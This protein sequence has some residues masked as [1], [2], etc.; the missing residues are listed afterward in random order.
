MAKYLEM[1]GALEK[2]VRHLKTECAAQQSTINELGEANATLAAQLAIEKEKS[3]KLVSLVN[4]IGSASDVIVTGLSDRASE[5]TAECEKLQ[6]SVDKL[7]ASNTELA[8]R[9]GN[10]LLPTWFETAKTIVKESA[11][12]RR[13]MASLS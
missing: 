1:F 4:N 6:L 8:Q 13:L 10:S 12:V 2:V 5:L 3:E 7:L 11:T 9:L